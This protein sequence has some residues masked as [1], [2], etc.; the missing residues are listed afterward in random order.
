MTDLQKVREWLKKFGEIPE[1]FNIDFTTAIPGS[2]GLFPG[3]LVEVARRPDI[4]GNIIVENQYNFALYCV[5]PFVE[6]EDDIAAGN[7]EWVIR[8]QRWVQEQSIRR[9]AP[10]FGS[11]DT[12]KESLKAENGALYE[13]KD[14]GVA[15]YVVLLS[16]RFKIKIRSDE[17]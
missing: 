12:A 16:A 13:Q 11:Y 5:F 9:S 15:L 10:T 2:L 6:G 8:L 17:Q 14:E 3:G 4:V 1:N 7:A